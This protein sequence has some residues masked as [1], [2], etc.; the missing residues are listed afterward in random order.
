MKK[1]LNSYNTRFAPSPSGYMHL[2]HAF[3]AIFAYELSKK[4]G[5][6]FILRM[7]DIDSNRSSLLFE[8]SIY[9]DLDWLNIK[10]EKIVRRQSECMEDYK[11]AIDELNKLGVIYPCFCSRSDIKAEIMRA[12]N[13]PHQEESLFYP[14]TCRRLTQK[15]RLKKLE[16]ERNF[17]WRLNVRAAAKKLGNLVWRDIR[18]GVKNVPVGT[19]GDVVLARKDVPTSYHLSVTLDDHIQRIGLV[20]RGEDLVESTHI[21]KIIQLLLGLKSPLY[22]HHP[23]ILDSNGQRLSKRNRAQTLKSLKSKGYK[24]EDVIDLFG[25]KNI[26][27][28]L[29]LIK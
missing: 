26:L 29:E 10:Y 18:L 6:N 1:Y 7:E 28:L 8:Q 17:A 2:G 21:H 14:G 9:E 24:R 12:G 16:K 23:L 22:F 27:S 3:S 25:K 20:S 5:G 4:L 11:A 19:I 15:E 13:A